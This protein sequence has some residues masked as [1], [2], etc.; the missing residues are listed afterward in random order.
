[1]YTGVSPCTQGNLL[2]AQHLLGTWYE[3]GTGVA[4]NAAEAAA[5]FKKAAD[6]VGR[7]GWKCQSPC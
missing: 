3:D 1:M 7:A 2:D 6:Q 4:R 5:W